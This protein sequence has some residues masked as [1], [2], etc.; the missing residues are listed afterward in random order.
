MAWQR[1]VSTG[2]GSDRVLSRRYPPATAPG[3]DM[4]SLQSG[5]FWN[6]L[7]LGAWENLRH[8]LLYT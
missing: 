6:F 4:T 3:I 8:G 2:S 5:R 1:W 7:T